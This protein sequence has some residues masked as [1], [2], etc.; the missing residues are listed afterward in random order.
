MNAET[1]PSRLQGRA[2]IGIA[3]LAVVA[4][5]LGLVLGGGPIQARKERRDETRLDDLTRL[6]SHI[7]CLSRQ[8]DQFVMP[9][10]F[11]ETDGCPGPVRLD[12][13]YT[14]AA[15]RIEPLPEARYRLCA[16]F[17]LPPD[18]NRPR[19]VARRRD[20]HCVVHDLPRAGMHPPPEL[21]PMERFNVVP[22][23]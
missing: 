22:A 5:G 17:E 13:P 15:Y 9:T 8:G 11:S 20:G 16:D 10:D 4:I 1:S 7:D 6:S 21:V 14:G 2:S 19:W 23:D 3:V 12:D 18:E